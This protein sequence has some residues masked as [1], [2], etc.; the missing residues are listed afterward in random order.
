M[1]RIYTEKEVHK[2]IG[3]AT[4]A[5]FKSG[6]DHGYKLATDEALRLMRNAFPDELEEVAAARGSNF[7]TR[8][9]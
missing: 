4:I 7:E 5:A 6:F 8:K 2:L 9:G 3:Q 1:E